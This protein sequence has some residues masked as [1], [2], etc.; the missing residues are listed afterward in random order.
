M[1]P[2]S[3]EF[4]IIRRYFTRPTHRAILGIG[5]DAAL[6]PYTETHDLAISNDTLVADQHFFADTDPGKIGHK[7]LAV[8]LSD[9]AA[10]GATPRWVSLALTL[11]KNLTN[12]NSGWLGAFADG[13]F[14]LA[15]QYQI[16]LIGGDTTC[17]PLNIGV[18]IMGEVAKGKALKRSGAMPD[19][20]IWIS[21]QLGNAALA[22][23][24]LQHQITLAP[25]ELTV[26]LPA[27][28]IPLARIELGQ[29]LVDL[30]HSAIDISDG[31]LADL[32]HILESSHVGAIIHLEKVPR[33]SVM[34]RYLSQT[35]AVNCLLAGG[36][37]YELC[38]TA[39][40]IKHNEII[41]LSQELAVPLTCIG[42]ITQGKELL[43]LDSNGNTITQEKKGY[44]H[45]LT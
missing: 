10:M 5:D 34:Q 12:M 6:I 42:K 24:H 40:E 37:D 9:M 4:D 1:T 29:Q 36:D 32:G 15:N 35:C 14:M 39:P 18:Q 30:A 41:Q 33:S 13:F 31:L 8:N 28:N 2:V 27:L 7:A 17:G 23:A 11:P 38:F 3:S 20:D 16:E 26:C 19:D 45:F 21:G 22:L 43:I 25:E 44:D